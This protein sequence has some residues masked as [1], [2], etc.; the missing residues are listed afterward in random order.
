MTIKLEGLDGN[1]KPTSM[2]YDHAA[3]IRDY[4]DG[5]LRPFEDGSLVLVGDRSAWTR[6]HFTAIP[7][8]LRATMREEFGDSEAYDP[9]AQVDGTA[10]TSHG[11]AAC[12]YVD[13]DGMSRS[14][15][16]ADFFVMENTGEI[17]ACWDDGSDDDA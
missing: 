4:T 5:E 14:P 16:T 8:F 9:D 1:G 2:T 17:V 7:A 12:Y 6:P 10:F 15:L 13:G 11:L 3:E